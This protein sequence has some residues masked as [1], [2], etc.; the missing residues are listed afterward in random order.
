MIKT[1]FFYSNPI[2]DPYQTL[3]LEE[4]M[5]EHVREGEITLYLY[6]HGDSVIIG[7]NQNAWGE[8]RHDALV[9][10]GGKLARRI[11]GGGAVF[12]DMHNLN[13]SFVAWREDYDLHRQLKVILDAVKSFGI[14]AEFSGRNDILADGRNFSGNAFCYR[15][16][17]AFHHG[18]I[19]IGADMTK[20]A[21]YLSV[22]KDKIESKGIASV[23]SRVVNLRD[24][25]PDIT[26]QNMAEALKKS[27]EGEYG[28]AR[29]YPIT[30]EAQAEVAR[31]A[32]RNESWDW[33]FGQSP[34]FDIHIA[35][36][37]EWGGIELMFSLKDAVI[38]S[39]R[40][41]SD[42]MDAD[43]IASIPQH[44]E[45]VQFRSAPLAEAV[46]AIPHT[47]EQREMLEDIAAYIEK[48]GY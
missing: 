10:D 4:Y 36:R 29:P 12:H 11:S 30:A 6:T 35:T 26:P 16:N 24:L 48:Q 23:R 40:I 13:F 14:D 15:K 21:K 39:A 38:E 25:N 42:A 41:F 22:P 19:L 3:A 45:G 18:T 32:K 1:R 47:K 17:G 44:L 37:F 33:L 43:F 34:S 9:K 7:R 2:H 31:L 46:R 8:C 28:A 27:F 5:V 20:L